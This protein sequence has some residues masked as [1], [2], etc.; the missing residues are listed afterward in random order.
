MAFYLYRKTGC[1]VWL[2]TTIKWASVFSM[3][4]GCTIGVVMNFIIAC[5]GRADFGG[6]IP[7][8][9]VENLAVPGAMPTPWYQWLYVLVLGGG[10]NQIGLDLITWKV[11]SILEKSGNDVINWHDQHK[12]GAFLLVFQVRSHST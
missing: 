4:W 2:A 7:G 6:K 12:F 3:F 10:L 11:A 5:G 8:D 1:G 9:G